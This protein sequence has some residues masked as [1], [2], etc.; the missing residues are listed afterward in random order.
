MSCPSSVIDALTARP[1]VHRQF[2][3]VLYRDGLR[4]VTRVMTTSTREPPGEELVVAVIGKLF[5]KK[6]EPPA[7][8]DHPAAW[9][10]RVI[11]HLTIDQFRPGQAQKRGG[12]ETMDEFDESRPTASSVEIHTSSVEQGIDEMR[13]KDAMTRNAIEGK[14]AA[15]PRL[16]LLSF[17]LARHIQKRHVDEAKK[18]VDRS[19]KELNGGLLRTAEET[20]IRL[21]EGIMAPFPKGVADDDRGRLELAFILR[22]THS[23]PASHWA[24]LDRAAVMKARDLVRKWAGRGRT[25]LAR[26]MKAEGV[27]S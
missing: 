27:A 11:V 14:I 4:W 23:G 16:G 1:Y 22:S 24:T 8:M 26:L 3:E 9:L 19:K 7:D 17:Y 2:C 12:G 10:A 25:E 6:L 21:R 18:Q 5:E 15:R 13:A 20:W